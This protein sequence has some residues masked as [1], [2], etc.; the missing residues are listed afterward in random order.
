MEQKHLLDGKSIKESCCESLR[1]TITEARSA[2]L[3]LS[4]FPEYAETAEAPADV[5]T[6]RYG[7]TVPGGSLWCKQLIFQIITHFLH[8]C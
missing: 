1:Q 2:Q 5:L 3:T 8:H 7:Q 4:V 6:G